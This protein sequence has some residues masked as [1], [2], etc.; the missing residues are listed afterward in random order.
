[1]NLWAHF[2]Y[3]IPAG[4][5]N[6]EIAAKPSDVD[7]KKAGLEYVRKQHPQHLMRYPCC[8]VGIPVRYSRHDAHINHLE[9]THRTRR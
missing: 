6:A 5:V 1:V 7:S 2:D 4:P 8:R 3:I 9:R